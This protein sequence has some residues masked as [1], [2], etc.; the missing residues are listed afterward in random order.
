MHYADADLVAVVARLVDR[1]LRQRRVVQLHDTVTTRLD[2]T[3]R[4]VRVEGL[5]GL[6]QRE[7]RGHHRVEIHASRLDERDRRRPRVG[8]AEHPGEHQLAVLDQLCRQL[9]RLGARADQDHG[10]GRPHRADAVDDGRRRAGG[11]DERID[12][13]TRRWRSAVGSSTVGRP[14]RSRLLAAGLVGIA[15]DDVGGA[16]GPRELGHHDAD[17]PRAG[18]QHARS[19][20]DAGLADRGDADGQRLTQRGGVI[21]HRVGHRMGEPRADGDVIAERAVHRRGGE[22]P[23]VRAQVVVAA[24]GL[25]AVGVGPLRLDRHPL[26]DAR[27]GPR[28]SPTPTIVPA[29][30]WPSTSGASTTK[31]PT[32]P[33]R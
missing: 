32:R 2:A 16:V 23:H 18:D 31:L 1:D 20:V 6:L 19:A 10:A 25:L 17:R 7:A 30:S 3:R 5:G 28:D 24:A 8:V 33:C 9:H 13:Q 22:E 26:S 11:V 29:A 4:A 12:T 15:D 21:G 27:R 14:E